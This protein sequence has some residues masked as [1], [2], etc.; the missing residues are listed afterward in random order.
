LEVCFDRG[1]ALP[2]ANVTGKKCPE[3]F[4]GLWYDCRTYHGQKGG[5]ILSEIPEYI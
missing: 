4:T 1:L 3:M 5:T 2:Q